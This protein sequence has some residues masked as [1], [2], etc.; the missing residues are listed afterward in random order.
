MKTI[1][2][3]NTK[4]GVGKT[5]TTIN[6]GAALAARGLRVLLF[7][8]DMQAGLSNHFG[9]DAGRGS[10]AD[11]LS[12]AVGIEECMIE[13]RPDLMAVPA[14]A[15]IERV[16]RELTSESG[17][18]VRLKRAVKRLARHL[19]TLPR[20]E[21]FDVMLIDCPSGWGPVARNALLASDAMLVPINSE[22]ASITC[23]TTTIA[24]AR[25][26]GEYHDH[27]IELLGVLVTRLRPTNIA[28]A[29]EESSD[30][31]WG[32]EVFKTRIR[33]AERVNEL[34][35][36][37][38]TL[39]DRAGSKVGEDYDALACE[40]MERAKLGNKLGAVVQDNKK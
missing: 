33:Q 10:S 25:L 14:N 7:D 21:S 16:E 5:V 15:T 20:A 4:G 9:L 22:P 26:L 8:V 13:L 12:G 40:V 3:I 34:G 19:S 32:A 27:E 30:K 35:V 31:T 18:E 29:V 6:L 1:S 38:E 24:E 2:I 23:A 36:H 28:R 39:S 17:G 37:G 11:V